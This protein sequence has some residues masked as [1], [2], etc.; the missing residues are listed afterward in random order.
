MFRA[1]R[2]WPQERNRCLS[3]T[4][5]N[6][7]GTVIKH[8]EMRLRKGGWGRGRAN[9]HKFCTKAKVL[10]SLAAIMNYIVGMLTNW[11][12]WIDRVVACRGLMVELISAESSTDFPNVWKGIQSNSYSDLLIRWHPLTDRFTAPGVGWYKMNKCVRKIE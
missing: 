12:S 9:I 2:F 7:C 6:A 11:E 4:S 10:Q 5:K 3:G 8:C 1:C